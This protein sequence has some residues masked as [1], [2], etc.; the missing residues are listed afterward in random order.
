MAK[1]VKPDEQ[2]FS[3]RMAR[4]APDLWPML[5]QLYG[6]HPSY[7]QFCTDLTAASESGRRARQT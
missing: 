1:A 2:I 7:S 5:E 4:S 6:Q 3:L